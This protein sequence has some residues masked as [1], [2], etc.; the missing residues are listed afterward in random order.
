ML[1]YTKLRVS[2]TLERAY[3][4]RG[5][6]DIIGS[7]KLV[8]TSVANSEV[9]DTSSIE[10]DIDVNAFQRPIASLT[11]VFGEWPEKL[12]RVL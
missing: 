1:Q 10:D 11:A 3:T 8:V 4:F 12:R 7:K 6:P 2:C 5:A 9:E